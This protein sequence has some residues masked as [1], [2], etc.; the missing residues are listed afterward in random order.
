[1]STNNLSFVQKPNNSTDKVPVITN[2]TP[3]VG[4]MLYKDENIISLFYYKLMLKIYKGSDDTGLHIGTLRQR[5][6]GYSADVTAGKARAF[7]D[8]REIANSQLEDTVYDQNTT[9]IPFGSI[10]ELGANPYDDGAEPTP[11]TVYKIFS[12]NGAFN[13]GTTQIAQLYV[14][15]LDCYATNAS[16]SAQC[17]SPSTAVEETL[18]YMQGSLPLTQPRATTATGVDSDYMQGIAMQTFCLNSG[19]KKFLSDC[20]AVTNQ[21]YNFSGGT[22]NV[23]NKVMDGDFHTLAFLNST[24]DFDSKPV[25]FVIKY[26]DV[27]GNFLGGA[28]L[29]NIDTYGGW[30]PS[31]STGMQDKNRLLYFGCGPGNLEGFTLAPNGHKPSNHSDWW[32]YTVQAYD[33]AGNKVSEEII[34]ARQDGSCKGY[35]V[36]RLAWRNSLGCYDYFNFKLKSTQT[37]DIERKK[38]G[39]MLGHFN[40]SKYYYMNFGKG[41]AV[42]QATAKKKETLNTDFISE[43]DGYLIEK[44]LMSTS[45]FVV[46]NASTQVTESVIVTDSSFVKKTVANDK[47]IQYS[48]TIEYSNEL[49]TNS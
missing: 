17:Y 29:E 31:T 20:E 14:K 46:K 19:T 30:A 48:I 4:Y 41:Q 22:N 44:L 2:W 12:N 35:D 23:V 3:M 49:N 7:F 21:Y 32:N 18:F 36:R 28:T 43:A 16:A 6:N 38:Y 40:K 47:L 24:G 45:V 42:R 8:I 11:A 13:Q 34:F 39:K 25:E 1:M 10:H 26:Y 37:I 33:G 9:G 5:R 15:A 27:N